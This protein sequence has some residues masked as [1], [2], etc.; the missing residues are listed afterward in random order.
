MESCGAAMKVG[1]RRAVARDFVTKYIRPGMESGAAKR[2]T[3]SKT[4]LQE[5]VQ[6]QGGQVL[7]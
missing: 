5:Y 1:G 4:Q 2:P 3:E 6:Q 7:S